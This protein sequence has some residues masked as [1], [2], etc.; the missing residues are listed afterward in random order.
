ML[1]KMVIFEVVVVVAFATR[2][3]EELRQNQA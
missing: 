2:P 3:S 1:S